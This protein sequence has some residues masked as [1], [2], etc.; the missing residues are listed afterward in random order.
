MEEKGLAD[1]VT[2]RVM[3][4]EEAKSK[5][6]KIV[7]YFPG[8]Y[9]PE[10]II[11]ASG[12][13]P[14][15]LAYGGNS[16]VIDAA[17][18]V[19]PSYLCPFARAQIGERLSEE[20]PYYNI[21]DMLVAPMTCLHL[22][23][24][25][26]MWE[27]YTNVEVF[28]LGI[29]HQPYG[30]FEME[31]YYERLKALKYRLEAL[32]GNEI[33]TVEIRKAIDLYNRIREF[34]KKISLTRK[35]S[36]PPISSLEFIKLNHASFYADP[37]VMVDILE[38]VYHELQKKLQFSADPMPRLL[39]IG[40]NIGNGDYKILGLVKEAGG[41]IVVEEL[42]EGIRYYW[43]CIENSGDLFQCLAKGYLRDRLPCAFMMSSAKKRFDFSMQLIE[44]FSISG[45]IW[46]EL[47]NCETYDAESYFFTQR[48]REKNIPML[49]IESDYSMA[50]VGQLRT[51][52]EA[53]IEVV[54]EAQGND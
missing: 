33:T 26:D 51:R 50:D 29:P 25:A 1:H 14:I 35:L 21:I 7:G 4:L 43:Q 9:V 12:A 17:F 18:S 36:C 42:C 34:L 8:N 27:Y 53:F 37:V 16:N 48:I 20:N 13:V 31:Y 44:D 52:I 40:P 11:Y 6:T 19:S 46:Y 15:C 22:K 39:L 54:K 24:I 32:T 47:L 10:E 23:K 28:R 2:K 3:E 5:G 49:L 38:S 45:V 41:E 30:D